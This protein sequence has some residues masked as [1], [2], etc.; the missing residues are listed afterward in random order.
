MI[1]TT[2][3]KFEMSEL[4]VNQVFSGRKSVQQLKLVLLALCTSLLLALPDAAMAQQKA[5]NYAKYWVALTDKNES[6]YRIDEPQEFLSQRAIERRQR[7]GISI[8]ANDL[9]VSPTYQTEIKNTGAKLLYASRWMNGVLLQIED[10]TILQA[11]LDLPFVKSGEAIAPKRKPNGK[12]QLRFL[13]EEIEIFDNEA[14][15][16]STFGQLQMLNGDYLHAHGYTGKGMTVAVFDV[17]FTGVNHLEA[18]AAMRDENRLLGSH[19]FVDGDEDAFSGG[20]HGTQVLSTMAAKLEGVFV[21]SAPDAAYWLFRTE[22]GASE[23]HVEE[24][25]WLAAAE[26]SDSVG[27]DVINSSLGYSLFDGSTYSYSYEDMD[28]NTTIITRAADL[29]ASKGILVVTSAG[30]QGQKPWRYITAP[31]DGD[32]VLTVG[33]VDGSESYASFSSKGPAYDGRTKPDV[34]AQGKGMALIHSNGNIFDT[35]SGT[36][37]SSPIVAGLAACLWQANP[38]AGNMD[39]LQAIQRSASQYQNPDDLMGYGIP[40]F[41]RAMFDIINA[42]F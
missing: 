21:G 14:Y 37:Y 7:A 25:N 40:D 11:V 9:P 39:V 16:G 17:G 34:A 6:P 41:Y 4:L 28:G 30:N 2:R 1:S 26:F 29:A 5:A 8:T 18:F 10:S 15:Y 22:D 12:S 31:A 27:V 24:Y 3:Y 42:R 13:K 38:S 23:T 32:S 20:N 35:G 19:D 36:S 33:A